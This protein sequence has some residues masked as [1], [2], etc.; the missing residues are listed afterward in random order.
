MHRVEKADVTPAQ[1]CAARSTT[2]YA[3]RR[4]HLL[5]VSYARRPH[6]ACPAATDRTGALDHSLTPPPPAAA[7]PD[8]LLDPALDALFLR[9]ARTGVPSAWYGHVPFAQWLVAAVWPG[10]L[11]E[12]GTHNGVSYGA[13]CGAVAASGT[14]TRCYAVDTWRGDDHA[15]QYGDDIYQDLRAF[16]DPLYGAFSTLLRCTF[17]EALPHFADG[18]IDLLHIDGFHTYEAV[19]EDFLSWQP[20]LSRRAVVLFHDTNERRDDFG[21]WRLW[22]ELR[23][24]YPGFEFLHSHGLGVLAAGPDVPPGVQALC[25]AGPD[26]AALLRDRFGGL[27][28]RWMAHFEAGHALAAQRRA[29]ASNAGLLAE[30]EVLRPCRSRAEAAEAVVAALQSQVDELRQNLEAQR[31][32]SDALHLEAEAQRGRLDALHREHDGVLEELHGAWSHQARLEAE[33]AI[34]IAQ[35]AHLQDL[36]AQRAEDWERVHGVLAVQQADAAALRAELAQLRADRAGVEGSLSWT[37]TRPVRL[38]GRVPPLRR[39]RRF[40]GLVRRGKLGEHRAMLARR[41]A[42]IA[43]LRETPLFDA[44]WYGQQHPGLAA[45]GHDPAAHFAWVGATAG[46]QPNPWFDTTWYV[47][48]NP[49]VAASG[50]NPLLHWLRE[51]ITAGLDP[52]PFLDVDWYMARHGLQPGQQDPISHYVA[53]GIPGRRDPNPGLDA[54]VYAAE[55]PDLG[56]HDDPLLHWWR[57]GAGT[58]RDPAPLFDSAWYRQRHGLGAADP[59][60][61]WLDTDR[62]GPTHPLHLLTG[63][64]KPRRLQSWDPTPDLELDVSIIVPVYGHPADTVRCLYSVMACTGDAVRYEVII[65]D[66]NPA[67]RTAPLLGGGF[68]E[69]LVIENP[70]NLGFLRSCNNAAQQAR[71][72]HLLFLN[73]DTVVHPDWLAPM[74]RLADADPGV[75]MVG[76]KL[77]NTDGTLQEAGGAILSNGW[78]QPYGAGS[79]PAL[80]QYN[81]VREVDVAVG[82]CIL[83]PRRAWDRVGGFDDAYA[84]AFYEEFDLAFALRAAGFR[85]MYQPAAQV[86]HHGSN[87]YGAEARDRQSAVNHAR[88]CRKWARL[89]PG[90]PAPDAIPYV[91]RERPPQAGTVL[92]VDDRVPEWDRH[93]GG[94]TISQYLHL[95]RSLGW[96]VAFLPAADPAPVQPYTAVLQQAGIEVLHAPETLEGWLRAN[97]AALDLVWTARPDVTGPN[98]ATIRAHTDAPVIYYTH[99]LHYLRERRRYEVDGNPRTLQESR[100]LQ[101]IEERI[102]AAVDQ[103]MTP[104]AEEARIISQTVPA[105]NVHVIPPYIVPPAGTDAAAPAAVQDAIIFVGG[106]GHPPNVDAAVWMVREIMPLVWAQAPDVHLLLVGSAPPTEVLALAGPRVEV[107]GFVPDIAPLYARSRMSVSPL[108][109]GAGVKGKIVASLQAGVP[110]VTTAIGNEGLDLVPGSEA[111]VADTAAMLAAAILDLW[112]DP[113]MQDRLARAGQ[114][115]LRDRYSDAAARRALQS[116]LAAVAVARS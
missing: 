20:K 73:G 116:V 12:L 58:G 94:L 53:H 8:Q 13:F 17:Q 39:A 111:L 97:G 52:N 71:G 15:G 86:T 82:A 69:A 89:L 46:A 18:S 32:A 26:A 49:G 91:Q 47:A 102:F 114:A 92:V 113:A 68:G 104:S 90:Q 59:L 77:L 95:F 61:H 79:D 105:A 101:R 115:V 107:T 54:A 80:P 84:P 70:E 72:R 63:G 85:V 78:G 24:Q 34:G 55:T 83:V 76:A 7:A 112:R 31:G 88:F 110:V 75:G 56:P 36:L 42:E 93:A 29:E 25:D 6:Q 99:D 1:A 43:A 48:R 44:A 108:R 14:G 96:R 9:P 21:V 4:A 23:G 11:V 38:L 67:L 100:R 16:H 30:A 2:A 57:T 87:S 65:A 40:A 64:P 33:A 51:G 81:H 66:D 28:E 45:A 27:G 62:T 109:Y 22:A 74:V 5:Q 35:A 103:V 3:L 19:R 50:E 98:L 10:V 41:H 37:L 60:A 106:F